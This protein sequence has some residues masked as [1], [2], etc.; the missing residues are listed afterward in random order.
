MHIYIYILYIYI[1]YIILYIYIYINI[2]IY[3]YIYNNI[4]IYILPVTPLYECTLCVKV[5][6][7]S[8]NES[9]FDSIGTLWG[10]GGQVS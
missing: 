5:R 9:K 2:Y 3:I 4:Y 10:G 6:F 8:V 7:K 1:I